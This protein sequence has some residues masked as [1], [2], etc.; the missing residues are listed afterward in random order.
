M[1]QVPDH[2]V[3]QASPFL[4][5]GI[6]ARLVLPH[7]P[8][9]RRLLLCARVCKEWATE[10]RLATVHIN[11]KCRPRSKAQL[12]TFLQQHAGQLLTLELPAQGFEGVQLPWAQFTRLE[13]LS[14]ESA[15]LQLPEDAA[16][17][18]DGDSNDSTDAA[19]ATD[20]SLAAA[21]L[22]PA[23]RHLE[24]K[25][26][27]VRSINSLV[28]LARAPQLT[29]LQVSEL[30]LQ[31][32]PQPLYHRAPEVQKQ[33]GAALAGLLQQLPELSVLHLPQLDLNTAAVHSIVRMDKLQDLQLI[34]T[35]DVRALSLQ[36]GRKCMVASPGA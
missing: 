20:A 27:S 7:V 1:L 21:P 2:G 23:L 13:R 36:V 12:E 26:C 29:S 30:K 33:I 15:D 3:N 4:P 9:R 32:R 6:I 35:G 8:P 19:S 14:L 16:A 17:A 25:S 10:A 28:R 34:V 5:S 11:N 24:L 18:A 31:D 22:L